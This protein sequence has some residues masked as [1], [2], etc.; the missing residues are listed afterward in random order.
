MVQYQPRVDIPTT[1]G[2]Q[3]VVVL[4]LL[5]G[6]LC[7]T[8]PAMAVS[9]DPS[10]LLS[11]SAAGSGHAI[12]DGTTFEGPWIPT[13]AIIGRLKGIFIDILTSVANHIS[14][15]LNEYL[16][17]VPAPG[18]AL[19]PATWTSPAKPLWQQILHYTRWST[20]GATVILMAS[21][22][23]LF[24]ETD[25]HVRRQVWKR[26]FVAVLMIVGTW[27]FVPFMLHLAN[28]LVAGVSPGNTLI[29]ELIK[30]EGLELG[31][32]MLI[33]FGIIQP[34]LLGIAGIVLALERA[35]V[36]FGVALWPL[37]WAVRTVR[38][39][40]CQSVSNAFLHLFGI[41]LV[42]KLMQA[43]TARILFTLP[44]EE[45]DPLKTLILLS[46]GIV[47]VF[48]ILPWKMLE[49]GFNAAGTALG[50][51]LHGGGITKGGDI[52]DAAANR[53]G[54]T[55][56]ER[57][58]AIKSGTTRT[59]HTAKRTS[60]RAKQ[61]MG[62][63]KNAA[64]DAKSSV[65]HWRHARRRDSRKGRWQG[66]PLWNPSTPN[67]SSSEQSSGDSSSETS[68]NSSQTSTDSGWQQAEYRKRQQAHHD[69]NYE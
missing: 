55:P 68:S 31:L 36:F 4:V 18:D 66:H 56:V 59:V 33:V 1:M 7:L 41:V 17:E 61:G 12:L 19:N 54:N 60:G 23:L 8:G 3:A 2:T 16:F 39:D 45:L 20:M 30:T 50:V 37:A 43:Y 32:G 26:W 9:S 29:G 28:L 49:I 10:L 67:S 57:A 52:A 53:V 63:A 64:E 13:D 24:M 62:Y 21:A 40:L 46:A 44:W 48:V 38:I 5:A 14:D 35:I 51:N 27:T 11:Q 47:F 25:A 15:F 6:G 69:N 34:S 65:N 58:K 42:T 22:L